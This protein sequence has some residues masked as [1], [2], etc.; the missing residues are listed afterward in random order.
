MIRREL[1]KYI[2]DLKEE[3]QSSWE[4]RSFYYNKMNKDKRVVSN[5]IA[6][7]RNAVRWLHTY[8][9]I[10]KLEKIVNTSLIQK[11]SSMKY[12]INPIAKILR[13]PLFRKRVV[14][15]KVKYTRKQKHKGEHNEHQGSKER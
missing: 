13:T 5:R 7:N 15:N 6:Y 11:G 9:L 2:E 10:K 4:T 8:K 1:K 3:E 12:R 14:K